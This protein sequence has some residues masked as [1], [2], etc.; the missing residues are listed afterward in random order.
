MPNW[1]VIVLQILGYGVGGYFG[2]NIAANSI[3]NKMQPP[4]APPPAA[5]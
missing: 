3:I 2:H 4:S 1:L 5:K